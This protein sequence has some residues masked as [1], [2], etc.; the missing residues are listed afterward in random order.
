MKPLKN[1]TVHTASRAKAQ[2]GEPLCSVGIFKM[3]TTNE[4]HFKCIKCNESLPPSDFYTQPNT[5]R[6]HSYRCKVCD[7]QRLNSYRKK[8]KGTRK[9][10]KEPI[11]INNDNEIW[12][13]IV[14]YEG[15]YKISNY[16]RVYSISSSREIFPFVSHGYLRKELCKEGKRVKYQVHRLVANAFIPNPNGYEMINHID[17]NRKNNFVENLEWCTHVENVIHGSFSARSKIKAK[18][19]DLSVMITN[20]KTNESILYDRENSNDAVSITSV[21]KMM[22]KNG[23]NHNE[24]VFKYIIKQ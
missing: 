3:E 21:K 2:V 15:L 1:P 24:W 5:K 23:Q 17:S 18:C 6:G 11:T 9:Y 13:D 8:Y 16:G 20:K 22:K 14:G 12:K 19:S 4:Q 10:K 7:R